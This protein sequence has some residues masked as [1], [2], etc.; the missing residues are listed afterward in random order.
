[1]ICL[2]SNSPFMCQN[3]AITNTLPREGVLWSLVNFPLLPSLPQ[4][5]PIIVR[6]WDSALNP[7]TPLSI[8]FCLFGI[9]THFYVLPIFTTISLT[10]RFSKCGP[11]TSSTH[12]PWNSLECK[13]LGCMSVLMSQKLWRW[14][15]TCSF[16]TSHYLLTQTLQQVP[17]SSL[18]L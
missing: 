18:S 3:R 1:M 17:N 11:W 12:I 2:L 10:Q 7:S 16:I 14:A 6:T 4:W 13:F 8:L 9:Q 15:V 5:A